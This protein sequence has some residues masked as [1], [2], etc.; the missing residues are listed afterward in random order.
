[1]REKQKF[2]LNEKCFLVKGDRRGAIYDLGSGNVYSIDGL[3][4]N[5]LE[6]CKNDLFISEIVNSISELSRK[7]LLRY[8][9]Q[10]EELNLGR[11][12]R[13]KEV[14]RKIPLEKPKPDLIWLE[15]V[16]ACNLNCLHCYD[17]E[18]KC[19]SDA[20]LTLLEWKNVLIDAYKEEWRR[21][22]FIG[23]E[24]FLKEE[25]LFK[26]I[27]EARTIGYE[28]VIVFSNGTLLNNQS[29]ERLSAYDVIMSV[30]FY[31]SDPQ[32]HNRITQKDGS[33]LGTLE[34]LKKLKKAEIPTSISIIVT[35]I[36]EDDVFKTI[37][38]L[39]KQT[40]IMD[41]DYD[42]ARPIG[43]ACIKDLAPNSFSRK[44]IRPKFSKVSFEEFCLRIKGHDCF[45]RLLTVTEEGK[46]IPC[47]MARDLI[48]GDVHK[49]QL[50]SILQ[51][52]Y[53]RSIRGASKDKIKTCRDCEY[54]Y[55]CGDCRPMAK[56][57]GGGDLWAKPAWCCYNPYSGNWES[58]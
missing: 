51:K 29:I 53:T 45:S 35:K 14:I 54:R 44:R 9:K 4:A 41:I 19:S 28:E 26:L 50:T 7:N 16:S 34:N 58:C 22:C 33:F 2:G 36:N 23:G 15:I 48:L 40:G 17:P 24:P 25:L 47:I 5:I 11:F 56:F 31:S 13:E 46:V 52:I 6:Q 43:R 20:V 30:S 27:E 49:E 55:A 42:L 21:V 10:L 3:S 8:L 18:S 37:A 57:Y 32:T 39:K 38:F 1:M 12:L